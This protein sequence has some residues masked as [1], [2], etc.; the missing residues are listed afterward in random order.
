MPAFCLY[1]VQLVIFAAVCLSVHSFVHLY[2]PGTIFWVK[3]LLSLFDNV[4]HKMRKFACFL[5]L[6]INDLYKLMELSNFSLHILSKNCLIIL[7]LCN[8]MLP[9]AQGCP[10]KQCIIVAW[11]SQH[12][13]LDDLHCHLFWNA[14]HINATEIHNVSQSVIWLGYPNVERVLPIA[15]VPN[16]ITFCENQ[17]KTFCSI[18]LTNRQTDTDE[19]ITSLAEVK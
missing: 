19:D 8:A 15:V 12:F 18:L 11:Y 9:T 6:A 2:F 17:L 3:F 13:P 14:L 10:C 4:K 16:P 7:V 5:S 1:H